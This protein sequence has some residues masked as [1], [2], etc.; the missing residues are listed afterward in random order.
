MSNRRYHLSYR[1]PD[2][3][4]QLS[5]LW[6]D[7]SC[8]RPST[9]EIRLQSLVRHGAAIAARVQRQEH[10]TL[11]ASAQ[12]W[13]GRSTLDYDHHEPCGQ[14]YR[15]FRGRR[16][17]VGPDCGLS[18]LLPLLAAALAVLPAIGIAL[19][20][21]LYGTVPELVSADRRQRA[22]GLF[23]PGSIGAAALSPAICPWYS[24]RDATDRCLG[25]AHSAVG[26]ASERISRTQIPS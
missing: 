15:S 12:R 7:S 3:K 22:F 21:V 17:R 13:D 19:N 8:V 6:F 18:L 16:R 24:C 10:S 26:L 25:P 20:S 11:G 2:L 23:Y 4:A 1:L 5:S 14:P 9:R